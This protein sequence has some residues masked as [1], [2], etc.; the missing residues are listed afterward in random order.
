[1]IPSPRAACVIAALRGSLAS[2]ETLA[3]QAPRSFTGPPARG[4]LSATQVDVSGASGAV[5]RFYSLRANAPV[6]TVG[7]TAALQATLAG[8]ARHG[9]D[10]APYLALISTS[11]RASDQDL[12]LTRVALAYARALSQ[13]VA[14]PHAIFKVYTLAQDQTDLVAGLQS[15]LASDRLGT[16]ME[17]LAPQDPE[18]RAL[19]DAYLAQVAAAARPTRSKI[20]AGPSLKVGDLDARTPQILVA[21]IEDLGPVA[22]PLGDAV[23]VATWTQADADALKTYQRSR[24]LR[25]DGVPGPNTLAMLNASPQDKARR[26]A[27]NL[28]RLRWLQRHPPSTRIDVNTAAATL[29]YIVDGRP[30]WTTRVVPGRPGHETPQL[31]ASFERLVLNPPWRVPASIARAEI[32]PKGAG[33]LRRNHMR[34]VGGRII[35]APGPW[36]ALGLVKFDLQ[37][38]YA[39]YLHDT[40]VRTVFARSQRHLSHG[41]VRV[42]DAIG[43]AR[44]LAQ[45]RGQVERF[46]TVLASG[47]TGVIQLATEI[48]V[49]LI[50]QT[51]LIGEAG[52]LTF[53]PDVYGWDARVAAAMGMA[54]PVREGVEPVTAAPLGP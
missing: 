2:A 26:L 39:I 46:E 38:P 45:A 12:M 1:M 17:G 40:P 14:D 11:E 50:Y 27:V 41:C 36:A 30:V 37:D 15:A 19:S 16:W 20:P 54:P 28:E 22:P 9:L 21:I 25:E 10:P 44:R 31:E 13:G 7:Q 48:P 29:T 5:A 6:W 8:A 3:A 47:A 32:N 23:A 51:A 42:E 52:R 33:Y 4:D 49:R 24:G 35:Q 53:R 43:F 34:R 18:Y